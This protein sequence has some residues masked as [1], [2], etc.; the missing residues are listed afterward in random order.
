MCPYFAEQNWRFHLATECSC[1]FFFWS[2]QKFDYVFLFELFNYI[3]E[4][5]EKENLLETI[6]ILLWYHTG[7]EDTETQAIWNDSTGK[8]EKKTSQVKG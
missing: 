3:S 1:F 2:I 4:V 6:P 5:T 8:N 7:M